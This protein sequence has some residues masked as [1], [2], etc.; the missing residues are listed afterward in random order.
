[1]WKWRD[2]YLIMNEM[3]VFK[4]SNNDIVRKQGHGILK[5]FMCILLLAVYITQQA[6]CVW[7]ATLLKVS[8]VITL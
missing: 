7:G 8:M 6:G 5:R 1:M 3:K 4:Q 2:F